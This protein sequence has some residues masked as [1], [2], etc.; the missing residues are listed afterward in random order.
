MNTRDYCERLGIRLSCERVDENPLADFDPRAWRGQVPSHWRVTLTFKARDTG[1]IRKISTYYSTTAAE[2][3]C[4]DVV[5]LMAKEAAGYDDHGAY[6]EWAA[7][8]GFDPDSRRG[9]RVWRSL[10]TMAERMCRWLGPA[11]YQNLLYR[12]ERL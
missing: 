9:H 7:A 5:N 3:D 11:E 8:F 10:G 6:E 4:A 12:V 2:P 1:R